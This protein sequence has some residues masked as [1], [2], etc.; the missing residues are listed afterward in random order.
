MQIQPVFFA[1]IVA[2]LLL[3]RAAAQFS[4]QIADANGLDPFG[5]WISV[6][7]SMYYKRP[8]RLDILDCLVEA[9]PG[10]STQAALDFDRPEV[11]I[12]M[13]QYQINLRTSRSAIEA[14]L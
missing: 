1:L 8:L 14:R 4:H 10:F 2:I 13:L 9:A 5:N 3:L 7:T 6:I 12:L 11:A